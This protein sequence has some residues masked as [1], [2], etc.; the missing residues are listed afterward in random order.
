MQPTAVEGRDER[1]AGLALERFGAWA[2]QCALA[3]EGP[4][5]GRAHLSEPLCELDPEW[6]QPHF[7]APDRQG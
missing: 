4:P 5:S 6:G 7:P 2:R 3:V 1:S